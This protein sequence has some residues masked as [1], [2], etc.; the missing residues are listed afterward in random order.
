MAYHSGGVN[1]TDRARRAVNQVYS[2]PLIKQQID[3][4]AALGE[5]FTEDPQL[6]RLLG[7]EVRTPGSVGDYL[8]SRAGKAGT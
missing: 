3:M 8:A 5:Q 1:R 6:R 2:I 7:Y 4:P